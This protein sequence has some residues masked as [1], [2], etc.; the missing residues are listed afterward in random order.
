MDSVRRAGMVRR[1][2]LS[3]MGMTPEYF[4]HSVGK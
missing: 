2:I 4:A 1:W 3:A